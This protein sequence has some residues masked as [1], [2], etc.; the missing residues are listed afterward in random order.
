MNE[1]TK[2]FKETRNSRRH[3]SPTG[4]RASVVVTDRAVSYIALTLALVLM[5]FCYGLWT[6][7]ELLKINYQ[8]IRAEF[9]KRG[10]NPHPHM[11]SESP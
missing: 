6:R 7:Y 10:W 1:A 11:P 4:G 5:L 2:T 8:D 9:I 3:Y